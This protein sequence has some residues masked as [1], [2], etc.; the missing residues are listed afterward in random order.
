VPFAPALISQPD[1]S[2]V[3]YPVNE[4]SIIVCQHLAQSQR[5]SQGN[6]EAGDHR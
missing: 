4:N 6:E 3:R 5:I 1:G 2:R